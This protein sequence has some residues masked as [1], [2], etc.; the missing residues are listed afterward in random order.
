[1]RVFNFPS[2][3]LQHWSITSKEAAG[4]SQLFCW[5]YCCRLKNCKFWKH[6]EFTNFPI[7]RGF[8]FS[9]P[10]MLQWS[11]YIKWSKDIFHVQHGSQGEY[12]QVLTGHLWY[13]PYVIWPE[14]WHE[15]RLTNKK[16]FWSKKLGQ[17]QECPEYK[18][19]FLA[20]PKTLWY[21]TQISIR[22]I[23]AFVTST[24]L[25]H[26]LYENMTGLVKKNY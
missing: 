23:E 19:R 3:K 21:K 13:H 17:N 7:A 25:Q 22:Y 1:M 11:N 2:F 16:K 12:I 6:H 10:D 26:K 18:T 14:G 9:V 20:T 4:S 8:S 5:L 15:Y 24:F